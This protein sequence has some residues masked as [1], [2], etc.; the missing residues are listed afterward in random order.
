MNFFK[1]SHA[2]V[3]EGANIGDGTRIWAFCH[4]QKGAMIGSNCNICNGSF[5]ERGAVVG[6]GVVIKHNVS[7]FDG[8]TIEDEVFI[9][10]NIAFINDRT[11]RANHGGH[12]K[13]EKTLIKK[14]VSLGANAVIMCGVTIGEYAVIGAGSV[15]TKNIPAYA[16]VYGN[17]AKI[18]GYVDQA[19]KRLNTPPQ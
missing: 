8:V 2:L 17:P 9:G 19:G 18:E 10:S 4:I 16:M 5:V 1:H 13:L 6:N 12:W 14:G 7:I 15:V 3:E 11:P